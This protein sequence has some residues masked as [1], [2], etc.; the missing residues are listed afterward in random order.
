MYT[1]GIDS[2]SVATKGIL[3]DGKIVKKIITPT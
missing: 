2:G 3:F 1:I